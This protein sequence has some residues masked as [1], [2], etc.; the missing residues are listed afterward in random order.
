MVLLEGKEVFEVFAVVSQLC[1]NT[2]GKSEGDIGM[3]QG[4]KGHMLKLCAERE[5]LR[6][7]LHL[8]FFLI[9]NSSVLWVYNKWQHLLSKFLYM[10]LYENK[11]EDDVVG[12]GFI[13]DGVGVGVTKAKST[14]REE[15]S[16]VI[17]L[18]CNV[19]TTVLHNP[20]YTLNI[21]WL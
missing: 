19:R 15:F 10:D 5:S 7:R 8:C 13:I 16:V 18:Y 4:F 20:S 9:R 11:S 21:K 14:E 3:S 2:I 1:N 12:G 6:M 17:I